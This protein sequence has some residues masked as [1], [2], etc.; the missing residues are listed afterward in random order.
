MGP[1]AEALSHF[2]HGVVTAYFLT[3]TVFIW[4]LKDQSRMMYML[5]LTMAYIAFCAVKEMVF[6]V[7][8][9]T[10]SFFW[11]GLSLTLDILVI[12]LVVNFFFEVL[13]PGWATKKKVQ[14]QMG[15]QALFIPIFALYPNQIVLD[16]AL[17]AAYAGCILSLVI[18]CVMLTRHRKYIRDNYSYTEHVDVTWAVNF[19]VVL[20]VCITVYVITSSAETWA[21]RAV[22]HL[23]LMAAWI[24]LNQL[25]RRH[26]VVNVPPSVMFAFP[27]IR[28]QEEKIVEE[29]PVTSPEAYGALAEQL[30]LCMTEKKLYLNPKLTLQEVCSAI[31]TNR[32]YLSDYLNNVLNTTFYDYV[33]ELRIKTACEIMDSMTSENKRPIVEIA[34]VSGFNS[35]STFNRAFVKLMSTTPGQ[36]VARKK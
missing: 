10:D 18:M 28:K 7:D 22:F 20:F 23:I 5:F 1:T 12:P 21:S 36:Y 24:Y 27:L 19:V 32:T 3:W 13:S 14:T 17:Y 31:G 33:N 30:R 25:A 6:L 34:E 15:L 26:S 16:V 4:N 11:S 2:I 9:L 8:G 35:I 29:V